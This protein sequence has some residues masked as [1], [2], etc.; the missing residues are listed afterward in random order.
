MR[1]V[2]SSS[3]PSS[4][5]NTDCRLFD[6]LSGAVEETDNDA[7]DLEVVAT[8]DDSKKRPHPESVQN[9]AAPT[10]SIN[11]LDKK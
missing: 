10:T 11:V 1:H 7:S 2:Q 9:T 3:Q 4:S 6:E 5:Q 8:L